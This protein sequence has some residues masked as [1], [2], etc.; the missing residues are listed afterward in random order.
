MFGEQY[1]WWN[2]SFNTKRKQHLSVLT[3]IS[4]ACWKHDFFNTDMACIDYL[5]LEFV[6]TYFHILYM[7][8]W[9]D[10]YVPGAFPI[11]ITCGWTPLC[12]SCPSLGIGLG[13][14]LELPPKQQRHINHRIQ[15]V[16]LPFRCLCCPWMSKKRFY[17]WHRAFHFCYTSGNTLHKSYGIFCSNRDQEEHEANGK[18]GCVL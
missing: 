9:F 1:G 11:S 5:H 15:E 3:S 16:Q 8:K 10:S 2:A 12:L 17:S 14:L 7:C 6:P 13:L 4:R 18:I